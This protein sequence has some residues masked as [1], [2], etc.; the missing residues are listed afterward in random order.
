M[1]SI[2]LLTIFRVVEIFVK[3]A[4][5]SYCTLSL[6]LIFLGNV[7]CFLNVLQPIRIERFEKCVLLTPF[8]RFNRCALLTFV[9]TVTWHPCTVLKCS[10]DYFCTLFQS[11]YVQST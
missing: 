7:F 9:Y 5:I 8:K 4:S 10:L 3:V 11:G 1:A 2:V 6:P